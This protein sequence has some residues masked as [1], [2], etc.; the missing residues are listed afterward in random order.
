MYLWKIITLTCAATILAEAKWNHHQKRDIALSICDPAYNNTNKVQC[1]CIKDSNEPDLVRSADC[2]L[3]N[4]GVNPKDVAWNEFKTIK[5]ANKLTLTNTRGITLTYIP[6]TAI[7]LIDS[8]LKLDVKYANIETVKAFAF[9]NSSTLQEITLRDNQIKT[10]EV[11]AFAHH[12]DVIIIS[13]DTNNIVEI[14][15]NVFVD[16]PNI[17]KLYLTSN[18]ITTI[19][20]KAFLH[21]HNL[22]ELEIDRNSLF[23]LN[24]ETFSGLKKLQ[25]LDLSGNS[26][27]VIGDNTFLPLVNLESLN[28]EGNKIQMTDDKAFNGLKKLQSL[29]L[30]HNKLANLDNVKVFVGLKSLISLSLR[31]N[32]IRQLKPEL[33]APILV[34]FYGNTSSLDVEG[35][36]VEIFKSKKCKICIDAVT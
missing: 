27:E 26:L 34:N 30:A 23:S 32:Q 9:A 21:L 2:Y 5:N 28:L 1:Y 7:K 20:D 16:L 11:N 4:E 8:V 33:M 14:N 17:E 13:L 12:R 31:G 29:S 15:R 25:K 36:Y 24:S 6:T 19:H 3:T 10:L 18:K 35:M 22:R